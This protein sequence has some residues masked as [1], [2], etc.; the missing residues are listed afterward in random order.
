[1]SRSHNFYFVACNDAIYVYQP[2][3]PDQS[4][5]GEPALI[6]H[7]PTTS[8][9]L[10]P[11]I[12][13]E[14]AHSIT[15]LHVDYIGQDEIIL[16]TCDDGDVIGYR[17]VEIQRMMDEQQ[18]ASEDDPEDP[19]EEPVKTFLHRN[20]GASAWGLAIHREARMIAIS[21]NTHKVTVI[22]YALA[23]PDEDSN[24]SSTF[25]DSDLEDCFDTEAPGDF[26]SP[27]RRDHTIVLPARHNVPSVSFNNSGDD[28]SGRWLSSCS[29]NGETLIW[30]L[31]SPDRPARTI[32]VGYCASVKD[33][34]KAPKNT[35][36]TCACLRPSGYPHAIW[37]TM[38]L[39]ANT[40]YENVSLKDLVPPLN[41]PFPYIRDVSKD[42]RSFSVTSRHI[43][44][45]THTHPEEPTVEEAS[46]EM[47]VTDTGSV[48]SSDSDILPISS[49]DS[50]IM[51]EVQPSEDVEM[52]ASEIQESLEESHTSG[53]STASPSHVEAVAP[54]TSIAPAVNAFGPWF[55]PTDQNLT[56]TVLDDI[57]DESDTDDELV[58]P[59]TTHVQMTSDY[60]IEN[61]RAYCEVITAFTL[62]RQ[63]RT[64]FPDSELQLTHSSLKSAHRY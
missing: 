19:I 12:D 47:E 41:Q 63:V 5:P 4:I 2:R 42:K 6:L 9:G 57:D 11:G 21:A 18:E 54:V 26:P 38:F 53:I 13:P 36:G 25:S 61:T 1:M 52:E 30:D 46:S 50:T 44:A 14:D 8:P 51:G 33:P 20:V 24:C 17:T 15:R 16:V 7:P 10:Q 34:T 55:Q 32:R 31:H 27:R 62:A 23:Q 49:P 39:D 35:P 64:S 43:F 28:P 56:T 37:S 22:A 40:A 48:A 3:F 29:I 58:I 45:S 60:L 59:S